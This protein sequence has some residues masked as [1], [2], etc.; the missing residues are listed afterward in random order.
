[1]IIYFLQVCEEIHFLFRLCIL[2]KKKNT[3]KTITTPKLKFE[4]HLVLTK[5]SLLLLLLLLLFVKCKLVLK[6]AYFT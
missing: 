6:N 1:M 5:F 2:L 4:K 3:E